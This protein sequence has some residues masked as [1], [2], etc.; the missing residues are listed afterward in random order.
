MLLCMG[1]PRHIAERALRKHR[2]VELASNWLVENADNGW[3]E[4][5]EGDG[6]GFHARTV[7]DVVEAAEPRDLRTQADAYSGEL[8]AGSPF[9][10]QYEH[11]TSP[12]SKGAAQRRAVRAGGAAPPLALA[13]ALRGAAARLLCSA[14]GVRL[15]TAE[16]CCAGVVVTAHGTFVS[17]QLSILLVLCA[18][19]TWMATRRWR[20]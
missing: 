4:L 6:G 17:K 8:A 20:I 2:T 16:G 14:V 7:V 18:G 3:A 13:P 1:F 10:V 5:R 11:V 15:C 19:K 12:R 9:A